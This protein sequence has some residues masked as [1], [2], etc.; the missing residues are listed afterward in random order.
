MSYNISKELFETVMN[1]DLSH[2]FNLDNSLESGKERSMDVFFYWER[3]ANYFHQDSKTIL[4]NDFFF[5][6]KDWALKQNISM[7]SYI[8]ELNGAAEIFPKKKSL[9][10]PYNKKFKADTEQQAV[11]DA[12][13]WILDELK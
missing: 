2:R 10:C 7:Y 8:H 12:C 3:N 4:V 13:Q 1:V 5:M 9:T 11:F 6:C